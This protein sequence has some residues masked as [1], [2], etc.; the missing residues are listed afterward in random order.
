MGMRSWGAFVGSLGP[1]IAYNYGVNR[2]ADEPSSCDII[3]FAFN[4]VAA[5]HIL[6]FADQPLGM[7]DAVS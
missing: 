3:L 2:G 4:P 1:P 7:C 5:Q 6:G